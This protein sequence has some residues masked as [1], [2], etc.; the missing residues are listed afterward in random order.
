MG[1][2]S[3]LKPYGWNVVVA[4]NEPTEMDRLQGQVIM[5]G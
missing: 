3:E 4:V 1:C 5:T 2:C